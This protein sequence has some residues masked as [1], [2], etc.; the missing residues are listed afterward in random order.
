MQVE[1][2]YVDPVLRL[3]VQDPERMGGA[4]R[5]S[6]SLTVQYP[7]TLNLECNRGFRDR[8]SWIAG[9]DSSVWRM[10]CICLPDGK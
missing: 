4:S 8:R 7:G 9:Q 5:G 6:S 3:A 10:V 1:G 2:D